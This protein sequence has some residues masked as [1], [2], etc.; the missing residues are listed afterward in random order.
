MTHLYEVLYVSTLSDGLSP[1]VVARIAAQARAANAAHGVTGL[2][3][4]DGQRF[5]QQLEGQQQAVFSTLGRIRN[6]PRHTRLALLHHGPLAAR[7]F[8]GFDLAF[9]AVD[10]ADPLARMEQL[11]GDEALAAFAAVCENLSL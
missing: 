3:V 9:S 6:D 5:C 10:H 11:T 7:R 1:G 2:L 4:F 8:S